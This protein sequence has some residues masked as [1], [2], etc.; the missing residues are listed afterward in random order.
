MYNQL[1]IERA[2]KTIEEQK[3]YKK[4][5]MELVQIQNQFALLAGSTNTEVD[6]YGNG[7]EIGD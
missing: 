6:D 4:P 2:M 3:I 7:G 5:L 1:K